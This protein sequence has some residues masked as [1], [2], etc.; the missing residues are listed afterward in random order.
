MA[1]PGAFALHNRLPMPCAWT[2]KM[3]I[4]VDSGPQWRSSNLRRRPWAPSAISD[5]AERVSGEAWRYVCARKGLQ[6]IRGGGVI[7]KS[8]RDIG[9]SSDAAGLKARRASPP[10]GLGASAGASNAA[11]AISASDDDL[12]DHA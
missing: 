12:C 3:A 9:G 8:C 2:A 1:D 4:R 5:G 7:R 11:C 6:V 10:H